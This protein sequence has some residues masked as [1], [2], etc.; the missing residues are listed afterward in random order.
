MTKIFLPC[1]ARPVAKLIT[2]ALVPAF[3]HHLKFASEI[4]MLDGI[5]GGRLEVGFARAFLPQEFRHFGID[6][7]E[8][9][10]RFEEGIAQV[11]K[12]LEED[13]GAIFPFSPL[14]RLRAP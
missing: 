6:I 13:Y 4:A 3:N 1:R 12:L 10:D 11:R 5:S 9:V 14:S 7:E 8:S 2:V